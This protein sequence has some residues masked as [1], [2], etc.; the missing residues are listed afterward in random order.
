MP[1]PGDFGIDDEN[2]TSCSKVYIGGE[3]RA[4]ENL[5][6]RLFVESAAFRVNSYLPNRRDPDILCPP[7]S[8]S[9]DLRFGT[10]SVRKFYWSV[11][12]TYNAVPNLGTE[13]GVSV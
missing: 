10:L 9:P 11:M 13:T 7:K 1:E 8:L 12:D 4:L 3:K 2:G 5:T 6:S